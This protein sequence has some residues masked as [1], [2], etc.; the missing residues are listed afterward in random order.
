MEMGETYANPRPLTD[1]WDG[2][3]I[4]DPFLTRFNGQYYLYCSSHGSGPGIKCWVSRD[5]MAFSYAGYVCEDPRI[6]GAY[7]P[8]VCYVKGKFYMVTSPKGSGHYLLRADSPLGP[9]QV[10]S[11]NYGLGIDG[12]LFVDDDGKEYFY[13]A[14]AQ[15][16]RVHDMPSPDEIDVHS[17]VIGASFLGHWTEG[18]MVIKRNGRYFLTDTGNHVL[19]KGYHVDYFVSHEGPDRGYYALREQQLLLETRDGYHALGHSSTCVGPDMDTMYIVYHKNILDAWNR[20]HHRSLCI[21]RLFFNGD[22]MYANACWWDQEAPRLP[23]CASYDGEGLILENGVRW[24]PKAAGETYTAELCGTLKNE[25]GKALFS[26]NGENGIELKISRSGQWRCTISDAEGRHASEGTLPSACD[27]GALLCVKASLRKGKLFLY[28]NGLEILRAETRLNGGRIGLSDGFAP[29]FLGFSDIAQDCLDSLAEKNIPGAFDAVHCL[30]SI[31]TAEGEKN[32]PAAAVRPGQTLSYRINVWKAGNYHIACTVK[33]GGGPLRLR[34]NGVSCAAPACGCH[35]AQGLERRYL[36][37]LALPAGE[38]VLTVEADCAAV[39]DRFWALE[40]DEPT[41]AEIIRAGNDVTDGALQVIGH[42]AQNSMNRKF[43][44]YTCAEGYGEAYFGGMWRD[45]QVEADIRMDPCSP[46][47]AA[48]IYLRSSKESW[49]PH[50]VRFGRH[51]YCV[52]VLPGKVELS[53]QAYSETFLAAAAL[54]MPLPGTLRLICRAM[55]NRID[56]WTETGGNRTLL[57]T[58]TDPL[59]LICGRVGF[60]ASGDGIGFDRV[61]VLPTDGERDES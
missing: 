28:V 34:I 9:F 37:V 4:G 53:K 22:R 36:G 3:E 17:R 42:K 31:E 29:G 24:L 11:E 56:V 1:L 33:A 41:P 14:S 6:A 19:S 39:L 58:C 43:S 61:T 30:E 27:P 7:A 46:D 35:D 15:G 59:A 54:Q 48:C 26:Q 18:P 21:D 50:Q 5:M 45:Y 38:S 10:I 12:S 23:A 20:P 40:A 44:G 2:Q 47:A 8:E 52:R 32:C 49:H 60:D 16:I 55:G 57:L 51:A 13:R 25:S